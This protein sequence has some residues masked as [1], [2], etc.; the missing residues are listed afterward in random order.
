MIKVEIMDYD[1]S[2]S[3]CECGIKGNVKTLTREA[4]EVVHCIFKAMA[5]DGCPE[6]ALALF[7]TRFVMAALDPLSPMWDLSMSEVTKKGEG[8][9]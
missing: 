5:D 9:P 8:Q 6:Q 3:K 7:R 1:A 2:R 4:I